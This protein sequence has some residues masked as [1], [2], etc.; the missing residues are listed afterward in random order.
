MD[1]VGQIRE[2][3]DIVSFI[4]EYIPLKKLGRNFKANCPF[5]TEKSPSFVVS[6]ERQIWHCFGC[7]KGG[8][9][10][11]FLMEYENLE[12]VEALRILSKKTGIELGESTFQKGVTSKKEIIYNLNSL[13]SE[14]YHYVLTKHNAGKKALNY[15]LEKRG[16]TESLINTFKLGYSPGAGNALSKYL[17]EKKLYKK[18]DLI[19][20]GVSLQR[21][22]VSDFFVNRIMFPIADHRGNI[23]GFSGRIMD[24]VNQSSKYVNT[25]E[26]LVYHKGSVFY[27]LN[28]AKDYIKKSGRAIIVEGEFDVISCFAN[29]IS[30]AIAVKGTALTENQV[31]LISRF[32]NK[33]S[34]CFDEDPAG[35]EAIK[36]SLVLLEKKGLTTTVIVTPNG[37]DADEALK[38]DK[39]NFKKAVDN[40]IDTY[41]FLLE[42]VTSRYNKK[43][44]EGKKKITEELLPYFSAIE[45]EVVKEHY[46]RKLSKEL[47]TSYESISR[48]VE[49]LTQ[50][51]KGSVVQQLTKTK[52][53]RQEMLEEYLMALVTQYPN[54]QKAS[55]KISEILKNYVFKMSSYQRIL[56]EILSLQGE[57]DNKRF[58]Q[59]L[60]VELIETFDRCFL[61][62]ISKFEK[63]GEHLTEIEKVSLELKTFY[64]HLKIKEMGEKIKEREEKGDVDE[65]KTLQIQLSN[66]INSLKT[67]KN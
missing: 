1:K 54:P 58:I 30:N 52:R 46:L 9:C 11:T 61:F 21:G 62:P 64:L 33:I 2:K 39:I 32:A 27:G 4:Q 66:L 14:F 3:I 59:T 57:F 23:V 44:G 41:D 47:D 48:Q 24:D 55:Q 10:Y 7:Q 45:N 53:D 8:D 35:Q 29:G 60:P 26:T 19:D 16:M 15:L 25:R 50:K 5:H 51:N 20:A 17:I 49:K 18:E 31:N 12:F 67:S 6:P 63:E 56:G 43:E 37:K 36:R 40:D 38:K 22:V 42:K 34:L 28:L 65:A 13:T